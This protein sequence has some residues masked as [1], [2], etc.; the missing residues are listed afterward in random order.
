MPSGPG[1]TTRFWPHFR[2]T[3]RSR[4][5]LAMTSLVR[6]EKGR[7]KHERR[8]SN[9][10]GPKPQYTFADLHELNLLE[11]RITQR[12]VEELAVKLNEC[13]DTP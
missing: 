6:K 13:L 10:R 11:S 7:S 1:S 9:T 4:S 12:L 5:Y 2:L 8:H 3:P